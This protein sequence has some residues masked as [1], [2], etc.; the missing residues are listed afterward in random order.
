VNLNTDLKGVEEDELEGYMAFREKVRGTNINKQTLLATDYLN[1]FNEIVMLMEMV[2]DMPEL[3]AEALEWQPRG[4][5]EHL[6]ASTF[7]D[8]ELA[9][10]AYNHVPKKYR[11]PFEKTIS[12]LDSLIATSIERVERDL[13]RGDEKL[14]RD[15]ACALCKVIKRLLDVAGGI[16]HGSATTMDQS[17]IDKLID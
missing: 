2:P 7:S 16:I 12:Q 1:H 6:L 15:N 14:L 8:R 17:E 9:A 4:Y 3:L 10:E 11:E 5:R 13:E